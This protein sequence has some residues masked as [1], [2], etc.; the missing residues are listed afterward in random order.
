MHWSLYIY[1][2]LYQSIFPPHLLRL[3]Y[4]RQAIMNTS[5]ATAAM[6][7]RSHS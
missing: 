3:P 7:F 4:E 5:Y 1:T 6:P 2:W